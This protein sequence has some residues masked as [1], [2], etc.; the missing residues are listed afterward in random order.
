MFQGLGMPAEMDR[1]IA[2]SHALK[3]L[4]DGADAKAVEIA[5]GLQRRWPEDASVQQLMAAVALR[6]S[7][8]AEAE[9]WA[10]SS[11]AARPN[12]FATLM[13]AA[14]AARAQGHWPD[15]LERYARAAELEPTRA[16]AT[17]AATVATIMIDPANAGNAVDALWRR[18][19]D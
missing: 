7:K 4:A 16:E 9:R 2:L 19:P 18:F 15:A 12:H 14:A 1:A 6:Q 10:L 8:P 5:E 11:L 3:A 13:L 17:F